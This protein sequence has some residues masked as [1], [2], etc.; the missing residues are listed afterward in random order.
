MIIVEY[1]RFGNLQSYVLKNRNYFINLVDEF[2]NMKIDTKTSGESDNDTVIQQEVETINSSGFIERMKI[3]GLVKRK[4]IPGVNSTAVFFG[5][6]N[7]TYDHRSANSYGRRPGLGFIP[8]SKSMSN[9]TYF[10]EGEGIFYA[11]ISGYYFVYFSG[12]IL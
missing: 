1:C 5:Q 4:P 11:P 9:N 12:I 2:G 6:R 7:S 3:I 8:Y 10:D